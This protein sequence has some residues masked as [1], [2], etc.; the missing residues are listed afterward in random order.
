M[1][2]NLT[3][4]EIHKP[5]MEELR[6][7]L[8]LLFGDDLKWFKKNRF[9]NFHTDTDI[10]LSQGLDPDQSFENGYNLCK[11]TLMGELNLV[12]KDWDDYV[13]LNGYYLVKNIVSDII[14]TDEE[15]E[16][17]VGM[18]DDGNNKYI[19]IPLYYFGKEIEHRLYDPHIT[20]TKDFPKDFKIDEY[21]VLN[22]V[23][24]ETDQID[25]TENYD[26]DDFD[27]GWVFDRDKFIEST[28][29][30]NDDDEIYTV[31]EEV[32]DLMEVTGS[33]KVVN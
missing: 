9:K 17:K 25:I 28:F 22:H 14:S 2:T 15:V 29:W 10:D 24:T 16:I 23:K 31:N 4:S 21:T 30:F 7:K 3:N 11:R 12:L 26:V 33:R 19:Y 32:L 20:F 6:Q 1:I 18:D 8:L 27:L 13:H 5:T